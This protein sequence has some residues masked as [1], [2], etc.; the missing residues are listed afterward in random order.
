MLQTAVART[1]TFNRKNKVSRLVDWF[2][3][4]VLTSAWGFFVITNTV[5]PVSWL[6]RLSV[7]LICTCT[8]IT[9]TSHLLQQISQCTWWRSWWNGLANCYHRSELS[10]FNSSQHIIKLS[11]VV[12][13]G[14]RGAWDPWI[15]KLLAKQG[16]FFNFEG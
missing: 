4:L 6:K 3:C 10:A 1:W 15:L 16:C 13:R 2:C 14:G 8:W 7:M 9:K 5:F 11:M 12:G